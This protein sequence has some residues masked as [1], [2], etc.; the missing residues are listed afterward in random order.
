M[1]NDL[2]KES[3]GYNKRLA[4]LITSVFSVIALICA[5]IFIFIPKDSDETIDSTV[6][7]TESE[8]LAAENVAEEF[9]KSAGNFGVIT[10][11]IDGDSILDVSYLLVEGYASSNDYIKS[12]ADSY[13]ETR[14][15][16]IHKDSPLRYDT[17]VVSSWLNT[18]EIDRLATIEANVN[19]VNAHE[20]G[21]F[22]NIN[23]N[24]VKAI[25][26]DVVFDSKE[27]VRDMTANDATW[28]G[29]YSILEKDYINTTATI[30]TAIDDE[31]EWKVYS[32]RNLDNE[33][34]LSTWKNPNS[35]YNES[36]ESG[37]KNVGKLERTEPLEGLE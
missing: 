32:V 9:I 3:K 35:E 1:N 23:E 7:V 33:Y 28:D 5:A 37:F 34:L 12:R 27:I 31:G 11:S 14:D 17:R 36:R 6:E 16:Y 29:S 8:R 15:N 10:D 21:K 18:F 25:E 20:N 26:V 22:L 30:T 4:I 13:L 24:D 19:E 2:I